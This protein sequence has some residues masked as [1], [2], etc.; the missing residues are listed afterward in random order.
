MGVSGSPPDGSHGP[1]VLVADVEH[2]V[3]SDPDRR[4]LTGSLRLRDGD[5]LTVGDGQ[6]AWAEC[7]LRGEPELLSAVRRVPR[8]NPQL[9]VAFA[10][11]KGGRPELVV[12]KLTEL[13]V[14]RI[15][16]FSAGRSIVKWDSQKSARNVER[17]R[18]VAAEAVMQCRRAWLPVVD[19][20]MSF[21]EVVSL[22]GCAMADMTGRSLTP[23]DQIVV[24]GPEG[25]WTAGERSTGTPLV[26]LATPVLRAETAAITAGA[27]LTAIRDGHVAACD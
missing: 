18:K 14:D 10:L 22:P 25:G 6:G 13:G 24:V 17:F 19:D 27:L 15:I 4:H 5:Q 11:I 3:L 8:P 1:H 2:P 12:Q 7:V 9:G 26:K 23:S 16:P 20:V 21:S